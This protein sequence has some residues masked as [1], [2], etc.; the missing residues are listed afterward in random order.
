MDNLDSQ[1]QADN[2]ALAS[3]VGAAAHQLGLGHHDQP[4]FHHNLQQPDFSDHHKVGVENGGHDVVDVG[5]DVDVHG[6][7]IPTVGDED[8]VHGGEELDLSLAMGAGDDLSPRGGYGRP[9][10]IRK[11]EPLPLL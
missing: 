6:L 5:V 7:D 1:Q 2:D 3:A 4:H 11:G 10:S 9:P 8:D